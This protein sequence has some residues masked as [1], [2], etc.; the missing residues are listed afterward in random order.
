MAAR[1]AIAVDVSDIIPPGGMLRDAFPNLAGA[2]EMMT[3]AAHAQWTRF[4]QG[5]PLPDGRV[6]NVR[7]G[8]Y[9][10]SILYRSTGDFA[11]E[12]YSDLQQAFD[13]EE[14]TPQR[15]MKRVLGYSLKVRLTKTGKRYL[16][17]PFRHDHANSVIG[18]PM[19]RP[20]QDWWSAEPRE[21]S[22]V[23]GMTTRRSG[24]GAFDIKTRAPLTVPART[25]HWGTRLSLREAQGLGLSA[26]EA[27]RVAGMVNFRKPGGS[28]GYGQHSQFIT[29]RN[30]VEGSPGWIQKPRPG[31][32]PARTTAEL[33]TPTAEEGF[34]RAVEAD[35]KAHLG[36]GN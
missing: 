8:A 30:M 7:T 17:I 3:Q 34:R 32:H 21:S 26:Q 33:L 9:L 28:G 11:G 13:I 22:H 14:G 1:F 27:K 5:T 20:V 35:I 12:V 29:F 16:I 25:Y 23:T 4:A 24:T 19:P 36:G 6:I 15:D 2:V 18:R 10:R 31:Y